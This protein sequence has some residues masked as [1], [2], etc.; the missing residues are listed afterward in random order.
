MSDGKSS[1][2]SETVTKMKKLT[3]EQTAFVAKHLKTI[4]KMRRGSH[5]RSKLRKAYRQY[6]AWL[7]QTIF[8]MQKDKTSWAAK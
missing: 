3:D 5:K 2:I 7:R 4:N 8:D 6:T 1:T